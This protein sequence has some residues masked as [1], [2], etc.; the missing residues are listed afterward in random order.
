MLSVILF[1]I[2]ICIV[3]WVYGVVITND[4]SVEP[5]T[6]AK[7]S[8]IK[9][10][11]VVFPHPDDEILT[12]GGLVHKLSKKRIH[13]TLLVLTKGEKGTPD[14]KE[15]KKLKGIRSK[16]LRES[17]KKLGYTN[18]IQL[19]FG[20]GKLQSKAH[21]V[22][23]AIKRQIYKSR[24]DLMITYDLS[25]LYGH[26]DHISVS[27]IVTE[28]CKKNRKIRL[29]YSTAPK[30]VLKMAKLPVHMAKNKSFLIGRTNPNL[31]FF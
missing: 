22:K 14:G 2:L 30:K 18:L 15:D 8:K 11:L 25:G 26:P 28:L 3:C 27:E 16:E 1:F 19:D 29:W 23:K 4:F 20:D 6:D 17:A 13:T 5:A 31:R 12:C 21:I 9:R 24:P 10:I 7:L